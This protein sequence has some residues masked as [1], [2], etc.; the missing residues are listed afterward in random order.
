MDDFRSLAKKFAILPFFF[1]SLA[2]V[3]GTSIH[4]ENLDSIAP[5]ELSPWSLMAEVGA[6]YG[7]VSGK[8]FSAN[9]DGGQYTV[10]ALLTY[11]TSRWVFDGGM[12]WLY[13]SLSGAK[14]PTQSIQIRTRS[15]M[16]EISP[17]YRLNN[18]WQ[19]GPVLN[20]NFGADTGFGPE[21]ADNGF[22]T[23]FVGGK[24]A[25]EFH[26]REYPVRLFTQLLT[27]VAI[28][29]RR[30]MLA[31]AGVQIGFPFYRSENSD[32]K[33]T[34]D[35][36]VTSSGA[37]PVRISP[38]EI[39]LVLDAKKVFF[40]TNSAE[41]RTQIKTA[42]REIGA[43]LAQ[44]QS[45]WSALDIAGHADQR[46]KFAY[47]LKLSEK[48]ARSVME[49]IKRDEPDEKFHVQAFSYAQLA[50]PQNNPAA[51]AKNRRVEIVFKD[52]KKPAELNALINRL[53]ELAH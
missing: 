15:G 20:I 40:S 16:V 17:R 47:N 50:D 53:S 52:V 1:G 46:G 32:A 43:Y 41:I 44:N 12:N 35:T 19:I 13:S 8:E 3:A 25:Y 23:A 51:W 4:R 18:H 42:L 6:G 10:G 30:V 33:S 24:L 29:N 48:R 9:P 39:H 28:S 11:E 36:I 31:M 34:Q 14:S 7:S 21:I 2:A 5:K 38:P 45:N 37:A 49:V 27:D 26:A 22:A